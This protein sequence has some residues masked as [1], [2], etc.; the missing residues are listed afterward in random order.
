MHGAIPGL[1]V[2]DSERKQV[3]HAMRSKRVSIT[4]SR[5]L[6]QLLPPDPA[7]L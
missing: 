5:L 3:E 7:Q 4:P 2:L 1:V 6:H